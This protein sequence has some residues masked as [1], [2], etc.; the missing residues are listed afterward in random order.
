MSKG[1]ALVTGGGKRIGAA[2]VMDLAEH[3]YDVVIHHN[4]SAEEA[5]ATAELVRTLGRKAWTIQADLGNPD[6]ADA[7][8]PA[9]RKL[10]KTSI[11]YVVNNAS[12]FQRIGLPAMTY[13]DVDT[14]MR[15]HAYA[16]LTIARSA[17]PEAKAVVNLLD[18]RITSHDPDHFPY[19]LSKQTLSALTAS[20]AKELSPM[21]INGV[22]PGPILPP[23]DGD[24]APDDA[25]RR[26]IK[27]TV[28]QRAGRP[29]EVASAVRFMLEAEYVTGDVLFVDG[30]RHLRS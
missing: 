23:T 27:A 10:A 30:G 8:L 28:M 11:D 26:G 9:A 19:L 22:A 29:D 14:M 12:A 18:T 21:R 16:P 2:I 5:E 25:L 4:V 20:L 1:T 17:Y 6:E 24:E 15:L 3:G 13:H 7:L